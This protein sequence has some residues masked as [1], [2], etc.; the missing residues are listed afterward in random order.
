VGDVI[1]RWDGASLDLLE[2]LQQMSSKSEVPGLGLFQSY[3]ARS[4]DT[5]V[6]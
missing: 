6:R 3:R 1:L 2:G 4:E 5:S